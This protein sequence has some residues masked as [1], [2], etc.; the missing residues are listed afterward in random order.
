[1]DAAKNA[2]ADA[3]TDASADAAPQSDCSDVALAW[4]EGLPLTDARVECE[5]DADCVLASGAA[6]CPVGADGGAAVLTLGSC[7]VAVAG[8]FADEYEAARA[9]LERQLCATPP[10]SC[11]ATS[12]CGSKPR[13][14]CD[15][16]TC[17]IQFGNQGVNDGGVDAGGV[18]DAGPVDAGDGT[19]NVSDCEASCV[20][21]YTVCYQNRCD[22]DP[23]CVEEGLANCISKC[24]SAPRIP[25]ACEA[26]QQAWWK[27]VFAN[28]AGDDCPIDPCDFES[29]AVALCVS[30]GQGCHGMTRWHYDT[31][32]AFALNDALGRVWQSACGCPS[33]QGGAEG[34]DCGLDPLED[35][36]G[37]SHGGDCASHCCECANS[38]SSY[39]VSAC[40]ALQCADPSVLCDEAL[41]AI[42]TLCS[43]P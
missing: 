26:E 12:L 10:V 9:E 14:A 36:P 17:R 15:D 1:M 29:E 21:N 22:D 41:A 40:S 5:V 18:G 42:P 24:E 20:D 4:A 30:G 28:R 23:S 11:H 39:A 32:D 27:C 3:A 38:S 43:N 8:V 19:A 33:W 7:G 37:P 34:D 6:R 2:I 31:F 13:A 35:L 25:A 16:G